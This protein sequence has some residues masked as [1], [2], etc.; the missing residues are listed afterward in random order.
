[1][2][3]WFTPNACNYCDDVFA[4]CADVTC[5][6]AWLP[7]Y[8]QDHR[9]M[10]LML[11]RSPQ[12]QEVITYGRGIDLNSIHINRMVR[13]QAGVVTVKRQ[14]LAY[15]LFLNHEKKEKVLKKRVTSKTP[16]NPFVRREITLKDKMSALS[17][18]AWAE[19]VQ[20]AKSLRE[21]MLPDMK[22]LAG[23]RRIERIVT[24]PAR[25]IRFI[26]RKVGGRLL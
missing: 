17:R 2:N 6:D 3:R 19:S 10:S 9:G 1:M 15:R 20:D 21:V 14:H 25:T 24:F 5:M 4:E 13:S 16:K 22:R 23:T 12:V 8:S 26:R 7:E 18:E 11:V